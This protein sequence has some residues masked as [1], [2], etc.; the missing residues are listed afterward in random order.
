MAAAQRASAGDA[1]RA[2]LRLQAVWRKA[3]AILFFA[4][5]PEEL[6]VWPLLEEALA[7]EKTV[8]LPRFVL[9]ANA[10]LP[11]R[12]RE[13]ARDVKL[14]RFGIREPAENCARLSFTLDLILVPGVAF[15]LQGRRLGRGKGYYDHLL[16]AVRGT[17][18]GV[19]FDE[20]VVPRVPVEPHDRRVN[21]L[22]TPTR[23]V[24][25]E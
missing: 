5:L 14:G 18:C 3:K 9:E 13:L 12:V 10:Y 1:A 16:A 22:L 8:G 4:P 24:E 11:Y 25:F 21:C 15:D 2:M 20:Q 7:A 17:T 6:D 23:W 19:A